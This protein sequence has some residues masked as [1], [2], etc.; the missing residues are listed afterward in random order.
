LKKTSGEYLIFGVTVRAL[1]E[2]ALSEKLTVVS[3]D[4]FGDY[5]LLKFAPYHPIPMD[6]YNQD[7]LIQDLTKKFP[8]TNSLIYTSS[9]ENHPDFL[10][11]LG[12]SFRIIGN[13]PETL[14]RVR[15]W[16]E[17]LNCCEKNGIGFP[18]TVFEGEDFKST[19]RIKKWVVKPIRSG[20]GWRNRLLEEGEQIDFGMEFLQEYISGPS[21]SCSFV[22]NGKEATILGV[23]HQFIGRQEFGSYGFQYCGNIFPADLLRGTLVQLER[24]VNRL[25]L[26]FGLRGLNGID[27][28]LSSGTIFLIEVNPR[29]T[30]SMELIEKGGFRNMISLHIQSAMNRNS[31]V[32]INRKKGGFYGKAVCYAK[33]NTVLTNCEKLFRL[34]V[35]DIT[36]PGKIVRTKKPL[37]S[38]FS[39]G[40]SPNSC[41]RNLA[42]T[43]ARLYYEIEN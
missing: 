38:I 30:A 25:T 34:G 31:K 19:Y 18:K 21:F 10:E 41:Y 3:S 40:G 7:S 20:G 13:S 43:A 12:Q 14:K 11:K 4:S 15:N 6:Y 42:L 8:S 37:F 1:V 35:R 27:F 16:K 23:S 24:V 9:L 22:G 5:D 26:E 29:F 36:Q 33:K 39:E 17:L 2:V 32:P 28:I